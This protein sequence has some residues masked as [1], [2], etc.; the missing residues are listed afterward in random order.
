[1]TWE[2]TVILQGA[3][4]NMQSMN[5]SA[6]QVMNIKDEENAEVTMNIIIE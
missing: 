3:Y 6:H 2:G 4:Q 5:A 1:M